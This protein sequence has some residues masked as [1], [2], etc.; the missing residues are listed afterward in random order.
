IDRAHVHDLDTATGAFIVDHVLAGI[1]RRGLLHPRG[2]PLIDLRVGDH[3]V[4]DVIV[5]DFGD[6]ALVGDHH[7]EYAET[8]RCVRAILVAL[9]HERSRI[10]AVVHDFQDVPRGHVPDHFQIF[11]DAVVVDIE[12]AKGIANHD[13]RLGIKA[14]TTHASGTEAVGAYYAR[15][16]W[17]A[18]VIN[19][20]VIE[21]A[22]KFQFL[23]THPHA[24]RGEFAD[25]NVL[26]G[27][28]RDDEI[29]RRETMYLGAEGNDLA[30]V[31]F[32]HRFGVR[33]VADDHAK[34]H[35]V[36]QPFLD[37]RLEVPESRLDA[38]VDQILH[39][40]RGIVEI[41]LTRA[42]GQ[43]R[44]DLKNQI[45]GLGDDRIAGH[46]AD[47][48]LDYRSILEWQPALMVGRRPLIHANRRAAHILPAST[49][50]ER[51][52]VLVFEEVFE[53]RA[54]IDRNLE[55]LALADRYRSHV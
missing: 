22:A 12:V 30:H 33:D 14:A 24:H 19:R 53:A 25:L 10:V 48:N 26:R 9:Q 28:R 6:F 44:F 7:F 47:R 40:I 18:G 37:S 27:V 50:L 8:K 54:L 43:G 2:R 20:P 23:R 35:L 15:R 51:L 55:R 5:V 11:F 16:I 36:D 45:F 41:A 1:D 49:G 34:L 13:G 42:D 38:V 31:G 29:F 46:R 39:G 4:P 32:A 3:H 17:G 52:L 21:S